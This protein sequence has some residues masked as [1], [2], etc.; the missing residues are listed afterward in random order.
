MAVGKRA[1]DLERAGP[2]RSGQFGVF[3]PEIKQRAE[4][5]E[6]VVGPLGEVCQGAVAD[7][8]GV[9]KGLAQ[10]DAGWGR[11]VGDLFDEQGY[12]IS[13]NS[14][15]LS[16]INIDIRRYY[17]ATYAAKKSRKPFIHEARRPFQPSKFRLDT[18]LR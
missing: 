18:G 5:F 14:D 17:M 1:D 2:F 6:K 8:S 15:F 4:S 16:S 12:Y 9:A 7:F 10:E 11:A 3:A 13:L